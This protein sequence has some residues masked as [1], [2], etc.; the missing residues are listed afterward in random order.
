MIIYI[1]CVKMSCIICIEETQDIYI[2]CCKT[3]Y[4]KKCFYD[5]LLN[6]FRKCIICKKDINIKEKIDFEDLLKYYEKLDNVK[7]GKFFANMC[8]IAE[9]YDINYK[10]IQEK[11]RD[12]YIKLSLFLYIMTISVILIVI[13]VSSMFVKNN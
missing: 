12:F 6:N 13:I 10:Q 4:H 1:H 8:L 7:K 5:L 9:S 2:E 3:S 11:Q